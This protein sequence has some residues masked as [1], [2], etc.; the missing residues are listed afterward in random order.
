M[1]LSKTVLNMAMKRGIDITV[2]RDDESGLPEV[3]AIWDLNDD[4]EPLFFIRANNTDNAFYLDCNNML[5]SDIWQELPYWIKG[6]QG[7]K[8]VIRFV[9]KEYT[10]PLD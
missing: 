7:L 1:Q 5:P 3:Y 6:E 10:S 2:W 9:G 4:N 8:D